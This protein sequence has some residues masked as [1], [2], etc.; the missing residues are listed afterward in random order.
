MIYLILA[1]LIGMMIGDLTFYE[2][3]EIKKRMGNL[4][5]KHA[6]KLL[7]KLWYRKN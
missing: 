4:G 6:I 2:R 7:K 1:F 5:E 3:E